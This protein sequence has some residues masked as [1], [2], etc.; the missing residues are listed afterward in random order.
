MG[1]IV[2]DAGVIIGILDAGDTH[3]ANARKVLAEAIGNA[4]ELVLPASAYAEILAGA[5][6][7]GTAAAATVDEFVDALPARIQSVTREIARSAGR[8]RA[9]HGTRVRLPDALVIATAMVLKADR[10]LTT[11]ARWPRVPVEVTIV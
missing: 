9:E 5:F 7:A 3:H 2:L 4:A 1:L 6:A 11:D 10:L 8:L